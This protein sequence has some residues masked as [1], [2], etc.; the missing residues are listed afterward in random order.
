MIGYK[1][2]TINRVG[3][4]GGG[5]QLLHLE[6]QITEARRKYSVVEDSYEF[7]LKTAIP[8]LGDMYVAGIY[9]PPNTPLV[10]VTHFFINTF[11]YTDNCSTK[12]A[13]D[14]NN[15]VLRN[16]NTMRNYFDVF[17]QCGLLNEINL[18]ICFSPS[19]RIATSSIDNLWHPRRS[20]VCYSALSNHYTTCVTLRSNHD[21]PP[22]STRSRDFSEAN[23]ELLA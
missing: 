16:F 11:E 4:A 22:K 8:G 6:Y 17:N 19:T 23:V 5:I 2:Y 18:S 14:F 9:R 1:S 7:F 12:F 21:S 13:G 10:E 15:D 3:R 20:Y